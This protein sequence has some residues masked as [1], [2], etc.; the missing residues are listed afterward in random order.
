MSLKPKVI[1]TAFLLL[2]ILLLSVVGLFMLD[3]QRQAAEELQQYRKEAV[4]IVQDKLKN[5]VDLAYTTVDNIYQNGQKAEFLEKRYGSS[6]KP[7]VDMALLILNRKINLIQEGELSLEKG[8]IQALKAIQNIQFNLHQTWIADLHNIVEPTKQ[9]YKHQVWVADAGQMPPVL[10][11][12]QLFSATVVNNQERQADIQRFFQSLHQQDLIQN[13]GF[14]R[15]TDTHQHTYLCYAQG[16]PQWDWVVGTCM[17]LEEAYRETQARIQA[18]IRQIRYDKGMGYY[19]LNNTERPY[20]RFVMHPIKP[21]LNGQL[22]KGQQ[23]HTVAGGKNIGQ[24]FL[25]AVDNAE[26]GGFVRYSWPK[27]VGE[28]KIPM[29]KLSYVRLYKPL[30]WIIGT[31]VYIDHI[32]GHVAQKDQEM[33]ARYYQLLRN[34]SLQ[35]LALFILMGFFLGFLMNYLLKPLQQVNAQ[36]QMLARGTLPQQSIDYRGQDEIGGI[37]HAFRVLSQR[38][39]TT[40]NQAKA[41]ADGDYS[42]KIKVRSDSD[43]LALALSDMTR[44]LQS[45]TEHNIAQDWLKT[46]RT[47]LHEAMLGDQSMLELANHIIAYLTQYTTAKTGLFYQLQVSNDSQHPI[48]LTLIA[49]IGFNHRKM[50]SNQVLPGQGIVGQAALEENSFLVQ[51]RNESETLIDKPYVFALPFLYESSLQGVIEL[52]FENEPSALHLEF[53]EQV[54]QDIAITVKA[55]ETRSQLKK[56]NT[57][58]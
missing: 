56:Q 3:I 41:I 44:S 17:N 31:G 36:L 55:T 32:E 51:E 9:Y 40:I 16:F 34:T 53:L 14:L 52:G 13:A 54:G 25:E 45:A 57:Y 5:M 48:H 35:T 7:M 30:N 23:Y 39:K 8:R 28:Q 18:N 19:W 10:L 22:F 20:P 38:I 29:P 37:I 6:M 27:P 12:H 1:L 4:A 47:G 58:D 33:T 42:Q 46:G 26:G 15:F 24:A 11:V 49:S 43:Q 50:L 2:S 21:E